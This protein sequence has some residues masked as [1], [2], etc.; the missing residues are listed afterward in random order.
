MFN[1]KGKYVILGSLFFLFFFAMPGIA[2][3]GTDFLINIC[4]PDKPQVSGKAQ[5]GNTIYTVLNPTNISYGRNQELGTVR[6]SGKP[7]VAAPVQMGQKI[8]I[9]L[10]Q[11]S[12]YM[13]VPNVNT[14]KNY[15][16]WPAAIDG[17][18]NQIT[19]QEGRAAMKFIA[20]TPRTLTLQ[21]DGLDATAPVMAL[22][23][24]FNKSNY[25]TVRV[26]PLLASADQYNAD[27]NASLS[28]LE[29]FELLVDVNVPFS[30]A[31]FCSEEKRIGWDS[32]FKDLND[33]SAGDLAKIRPL[34]ESGLISGYPDGT[35]RPEQDITRVEAA[36]LIGRVF[37]FTGQKA[38]FVDA[39]PS[40][41]G[42]GLNSAVSGKNVNGNQDGSLQAQRYLNK[43][44]TLA[45]LQNCMESYNKQ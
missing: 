16:E 7:G 36:S 32:R 42:E 4:D 8:R 13:Q 3:A 31:P 23:F 27:A 9:I 25:S 45:M 34:L 5:Q 21:F 41:A 28:R 37:L 2:R 14:Y 24:V 22:D 40:W 10:P 33:L 11:G 26:A 18:N 44:E 6:V 1:R 12:R 38:S 39:V 30:W 29:F 19:D 20:A 15:V 43:A 17:Q 35:L